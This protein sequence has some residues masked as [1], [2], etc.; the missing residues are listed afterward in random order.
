MAHGRRGVR[1]CNA[2]AEASPPPALR[3]FRVNRLGCDGAF[4]FPKLQLSVEAPKQRRQKRL[5]RGDFFLEGATLLW[6]AARL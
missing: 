6:D 5:W 1:R 4:F 3:S 2:E